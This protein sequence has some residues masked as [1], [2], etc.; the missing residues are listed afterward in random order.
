MQGS[1]AS[2]FENPN[3]L[4]R[5]VPILPE[6][7]NA[8]ATTQEGYNTLRNLCQ[9][10]SVKGRDQQ[11]TRSGP[12]LGFFPACPGGEGCRS[13]PIGVKKKRGISLPQGVNE[14][15]GRARRPHACGGSSSHVYTPTLGQQ[16]HR[17]AAD[18][19]NHP[20]ISLNIGDGQPV[21]RTDASLPVSL[22][23]ASKRR[24]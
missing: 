17:T 10:T 4:P 24:G 8:S 6:A 9:I 13:P 3:A 7:G 2:H 1:S 5:N 11:P 16:V 22:A 20:K 18:A 19:P 14:S 21:K 12:I 15:L 23:I